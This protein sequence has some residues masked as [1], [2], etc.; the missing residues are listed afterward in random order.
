MDEDRKT[1]DLTGFDTVV[2]TEEQR[3]ELM[4]ACMQGFE[5]YLK[6]IQRIFGGIND[7]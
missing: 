3:E 1:K 2:I 4:Q 5:A 7:K 6:A